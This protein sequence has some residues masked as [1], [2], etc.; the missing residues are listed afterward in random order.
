MCDIYIKYF[1]MV[2]NMVSEFW[3]TKVA[4]FHRH[5]EEQDHVSSSTYGQE[6]EKQT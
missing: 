6:H 2:S 5:S 4:F 1:T 3:K